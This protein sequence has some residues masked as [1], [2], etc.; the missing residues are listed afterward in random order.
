M[1]PTNTLRELLDAL[2]QLYKDERESHNKSGQDA[3]TEARHHLDDLGNW[4]DG[5]GFAPRVI[6]RTPDAPVVGACLFTYTVDNLTDEDRDR[7]NADQ[8]DE[9]DRAL[10]PDAYRYRSGD[11]TS[12]DRDDR[13]H[14]TETPPEPKRRRTDPGE[15]NNP[16][17]VP[18][19]HHA[20][21]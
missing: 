5:D 15:P 9:S 21:A 19:T 17:A 2:A 14:A 4:L 16:D 6:Q 1:D 11:L 8:R 7:I 3:R 10:H 20:D 18:K 12:C 13:E